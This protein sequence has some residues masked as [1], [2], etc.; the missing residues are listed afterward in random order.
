VASAFSHAIVAWAIG[1][2]VP[3]RELTTPTLAVG[4]ACSILPDL[5][6]VGFHFGI[7]YGDLWGHRGLSHS[8]LFAVVLSGVLVTL[9]YRKRT[10][11]AK[12]VL[13]TYFFLSTAS[14]GLLDACTN[15]GLGVAFFS[16]FDPTRYFFPMR[17]VL[18]SP[19]GVGE[20]FTGYGW[21]VLLSEV[22]WLWLP[23]GCFVLVCR[24]L[25]RI[26]AADVERAS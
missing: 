9:G 22:L 24:Q 4:M 15:G 11:A 21:Q 8:I 13:F 1:K 26:S 23:A 10:A 2:A 6:V 7:Q 3:M 5:D 12:L 17:P 14:H 20:F 25:D 19:L 18:V 16:P